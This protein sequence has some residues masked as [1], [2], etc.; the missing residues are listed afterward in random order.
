MGGFRQ[1]ISLTAFPDVIPP[2]GH[3]TLFGYF[4]VEQR[5]LKKGAVSILEFT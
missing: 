2:T 5:I 3:I 4:N 1:V